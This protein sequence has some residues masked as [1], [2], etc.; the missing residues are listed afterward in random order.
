MTNFKPDS[1]DCLDIILTDVQLHCRKIRKP[2]SLGRQCAKAF[3]GSKTNRAYSKSIALINDKK[4]IVS[5]NIDLGMEHLYN[6]ARKQ[7]KKYIRFFIKKDGMPLFL[8]KDIIEK[9]LADYKKSLKNKNNF[10]YNI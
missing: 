2:N 5:V 8:G 10:L 4:N 1:K 7:G 9:L 6:L 3:H